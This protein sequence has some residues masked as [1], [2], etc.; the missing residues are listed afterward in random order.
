MGPIESEAATPFAQA[1]FD[2]LTCALFFSAPLGLGMQKAVAVDVSKL[3]P[4]LA[5]TLVVIACFVRGV[6]PMRLPRRFALFFL[7]AAVHTCIVYGFLHPDEFVIGYGDQRYTEQGF[8]T[9]LE[10][11]STTVARIV[12]FVALYLA[13]A[14]KLNGTK[15][16]AGPALAYGA[17]YA[18]SLAFG[19]Y[20]STWL[21]AGGVETRSTGGFLNANAFGVSGAMLCL[22]GLIAICRRTGKP[23]TVAA[24]WAVTAVGL[25]G[26]LMSGSRT[27]MLGVA[28][29]V[30]LFAITVR[31]VVAKY[32]A[33]VVTTVALL[34]AVAL[35]S[36]SIRETLRSR[37]SA[38]RIGG[39]S[40]A[41][42]AE[43]WSD[44]LSTMDEWAL[45]GVGFQRSTKL[46]EVNHRTVSVFITHN[47]YLGVAV[48]FGLVGLALLIAA[49]LQFLGRL[50]ALVRTTRSSETA[51]IFSSAVGWSCM[52]LFGNLESGRDIWLFFGLISACARCSAPMLRPSR[53]IDREGIAA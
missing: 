10:T 24:I 25:T 43:I 50:R 13:L 51:L 35:S 47:S 9:L 28:V 20:S 33:V 30:V 7:F 40:G 1:L 37:L 11:P 38:E 15:G 49:Q 18:V 45:C 42:R 14:T 53:H 19:G 8:S 48:E 5:A 26:V 31:G 36:D 27:A 12:I 41:S 32:L 39:T 46:A 2:G 3:F 4:L 6:S 29:S 34:L 44:Y 16:T 22:L 52:C 23:L 17:G 21:T